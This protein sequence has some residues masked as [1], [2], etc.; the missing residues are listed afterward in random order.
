[1]PSEA[2]WPVLKTYQREY[3][4]RVALPLGGIGTGTV[5]LGGRGDLRDWEIMNDP[6]K[7]FLPTSASWGGGGQQIGP[8]FCVRMKPANGEVF[9]RCLES[10]LPVESYE[11]PWGCMRPS[12]GVP[13]FAAVTFETAYPLATLR[14]EDDASPLRV[15][16][17]A[18][19]PMVPGDSD[20]S[21][22]PVAVLRYVL[23][24]PGSEAVDATVCGC[25][26]NFIGCGPEDVKV[27]WAGRKGLTNGEGNINRF[28]TGDGVSGLRFEAPA[29]DPAHPRW[30]TMAL[31]TL[32]SEGVSHQTRW[33]SRAWGGDL[34]QFWDQFTKEGELSD[35]P[36]DGQPGRPMGALARRVEVP[37]GETRE[38]TFLL[39][40]HFPNRMT[41]SP[42][43]DDGHDNCIG[44]YYTEQFKDAWDAAEHVAGNLPDLEQRTVRFVEAFCQSDVPEEILEAALFNTSTLRTQTVFRTPDGRLF[45]W[46][47]CGDTAGCCHGSCT[48]VWNYETTT[49]ML[50]GDLSRSMR[51]VEFA[52]SLDEE[53]AMSFRV[54][55]PLDAEHN[56]GCAAA[57]GQ[58]GSIVRL[59]RDWHLSG[60]D[61][62]LE[63]LW[64]QVKRTMA[65]CWQ[66]GSWDA[67][68]DGVME[69]CQHNTMDVEY[70]GPNPQMTGWYLAALKACSGMAA[71]LGDSD[72]AETCDDLFARGSAWMD[73]HLFNG[74]Y[75]EHE[76]RL[77][78]K[79]SVRLPQLRMGMGRVDEDKPDFHLANGCLIDQLVGQYAAHTVDLGYL[80]NPAKVRKTLESI[81]ERNRKTGFDDHFNTMRSFVLGDETALLMCSY[82]PDARP[83]YPMP[84]YTEVMT[85][86]E[87]VVA[88]GLIQEGDREEALRVIRD[89]RSRYD[90]RKRNPFNEAEC[91]HHYARAMA[92]W[93]CYLAW[94][95]FQYSAVTG[96]MKFAASDKP[97][98]W[99]WSTGGAWG[100][101]RQER[102][103]DR[104]NIT[105]RRVSGKMR[106]GS[107]TVGM[108]RTETDR[109]ANC[110]DGSLDWAV[111]YQN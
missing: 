54:G 28:E 42:K 108:G 93:S 64:P 100:I 65:F 19:N 31:T 29:L 87:Y 30:G 62:M 23:E 21:G 91:G 51:E 88:A 76:V 8:F 109:Q 73:E 79:G 63:R 34:L 17:Q 36:G 11:G 66:P 69:G 77:F 53:G 106:L 92:A 83:E 70:Y 105:V 84:Y 104:R 40:W 25:L 12:H 3:L 46:E 14:F 13:R 102:G 7:G 24:N 44:N 6:A 32:G 101:L 99:F 75:Y 111:C 59:Y 81:V 71:H 47:G 39:T 50:F 74:E 5:S 15:S 38:V 67:D 57:D 43:D 35:I 41:W 107:I 56:L 1:M 98:T 55:L 85:G 82:P 97:V 103:T 20:A 45:G 18:F 16:L 61:E 90:G 89:V 4:H 52:H 80:H 33:N 22:L 96:E 9:A 27:I 10:P 58:M 37:A 68:Q 49:A 60:D 86:F 72:F 2:S 110:Q 78:E 26:P 94:T 95:G 48:H